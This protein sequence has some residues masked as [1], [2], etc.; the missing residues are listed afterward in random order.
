MRTFY[1]LAYDHILEGTTATYTDPRLNDLL[2]SV[3]QLRLFAVTR[4]T[5]GTSPTLTVQIE[6]SADNVRWTSKTGTAEINA[7]ALD[8][9]PTTIARGSDDGATP[10]AGQVRLAISLGGTSPRTLLRLWVT[11][12]TDRPD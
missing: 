10:S 8:V 5:S 2:G 4:D 3:E 12:R 11:G 6:E 9:T 1:V 7:V